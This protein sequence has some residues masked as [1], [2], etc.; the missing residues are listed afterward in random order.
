MKLNLDFS[1]L[2]SPNNMKFDF[3]NL[4]MSGFNAKDPVSDPV[5]V[6]SDKTPTPEVEVLEGAGTVA[7]TKTPE[8][9][10]SQA[11]KDVMSSQGGML[12]PPPAQTTTAPNNLDNT[13][14]APTPAPSVL[15]QVVAPTIAPQTPVSVVGNTGTLSGGFDTTLT[16]KAQSDIEKGLDLAGQAQ[17][18]AFGD[19]FFNLDN[20]KKANSLQNTSIDAN[21]RKDYFNIIHT[22]EFKDALA[23]AQQAYDQFGIKVTSREVL[24]SMGIPTQFKDVNDEKTWLWDEKLQEFKKVRDESKGGIGDILDDN[25]DVLAGVGLAVMTGGMASTLSTLAVSAGASAG[26]AGAIGNVAANALVQGTLTGDLDPA[27]L[28]TSAIS[29]YTKGLQGAIEAG[30]AGAEIASQ[31]EVLDNINNTVKLAQA[32]DEGNVLGAVTAGLNLADMDSPKDLISNFIS[33]TAQD[34]DTYLGT[35][36]NAVANWAFNNSDELAEAT[37]KFADSM[38][39]NG[40]VGDA[41]L[42]AVIKYIKEGGGLSDLIPSGGDFGLDFEVP[43]VLQEVGQ[44]IAD[45]ASAINREIIKPVVKTVET[46]VEAAVEVGDQVVRI[47]PTEIEDW[48]EAEE[49]VKQELRDFDK[50]VLQPVIKPI[51]EELSVLNQDVREELRNFDDEKLQPIKEDIEEVV[52]QVDQA[53]SDA[54]Q[55]TREQL[56]NFDDEVLQPVKNN[57]E[58][59]IESVDGIDVNM[60]G[61]KDLLTKLMDVVG[62]LGAGLLQTQFAMNKTEFS[63]VDLTNVELL[64]PEVVEGFE[65]DSLKNEL[66]G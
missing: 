50:E 8:V 9:K 10:Y 34:A 26:M 43:E 66:L 59:L 21:T 38:I 4:D 42:Q 56:A 3:S 36:K 2:F 37:I 64:E 17:Q 5:D 31:V 24:N 55:Y 22:D 32:V 57:I 25:V 11:V 6:V 54:N 14:P 15:P 41:S 48:K 46:A 40:D 58:E 61:V 19:Y 18:A 27:K 33:D 30:Q 51:R 1:G 62:G 16:T 12:V 52:K 65:Y 7:V 47:L 35:V 29:G 13:S 28:A 63:P 49:Y 45:G 23:D 60:G 44:M 39:K 20:V 53:L